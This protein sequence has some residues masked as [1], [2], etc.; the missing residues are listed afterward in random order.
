MS[1]SLSW[2]GHALREEADRE[3]EKQQRMGLARPF[4]RP[5]SMLSGRPASLHFQAGEVTRE[6]T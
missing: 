4:R 5:V 6:E 2:G 3:A 1:K